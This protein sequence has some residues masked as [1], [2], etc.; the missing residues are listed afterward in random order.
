M[1][2]LAG[3]NAVM[4]VIERTG[5]APYRWKVSEAPLTKVANH[6]KEVSLVEFGGRK[7]LW[8]FNDLTRGDIRSRAM[9][10][11]AF[12]LARKQGYRDTGR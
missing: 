5:D 8:G 6:E 9:R 3:K 7:K 11:R 4:P 2:R 1:G 12:K 10:S